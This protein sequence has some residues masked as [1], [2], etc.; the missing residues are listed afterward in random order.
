MGKN[1][2]ESEEVLKS[3][4]SHTGHVILALNECSD[5]LKLVALHGED[6]KDNCG[7]TMWN[8]N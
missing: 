6:D 3:G 7:D 2:E 8:L 4:E 5:L 1:R